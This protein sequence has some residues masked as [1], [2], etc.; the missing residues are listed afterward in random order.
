MGDPQYDQTLKFLPGNEPG[1]QYVLGSPTPSK[2]VSMS[3]SNIGTPMYTGDHILADGTGHWVVLRP[4]Q[5]GQAGPLTPGASNDLVHWA[6][7][8]SASSPV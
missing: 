5:L 4:H 7:G 8:P 1:K 3:P 6:V 2:R